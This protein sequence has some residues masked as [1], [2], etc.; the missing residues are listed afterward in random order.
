M[1]LRILVIKVSNL[2]TPSHLSCLKYESGRKKC[3]WPL[4]YPGAML[5]REGIAEGKNFLV[6]LLKSFKI[7]AIVKG[8]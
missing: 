7:F 1:G 2:Y 6:S 8:H 3:L 4:A 5:L